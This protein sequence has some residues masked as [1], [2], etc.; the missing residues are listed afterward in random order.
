MEEIR[1]REMNSPVDR[2]LVAFVDI[3]Y[4]GCCSRGRR[5]E[6]VL[7]WLWRG[8]WILRVR[9]P[10]APEVGTVMEARNTPGAPVWI[11]QPC[12]TSSTSALEITR[13][14]P[15]IV[16]LKEKKKLV[17]VVEIYARDF[18]FIYRAPRNSLFKNDPSSQIYRSIDEQ[19]LSLSLLSGSLVIIN[20]SRAH[21]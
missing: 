12:T 15:S 7:G 6:N 2:V 3:G 20:A 10:H 9:G 18:F 17:P 8:R 13:V 21:D 1:R 4:R 19:F 5:R 16:I 14:Q 11:V